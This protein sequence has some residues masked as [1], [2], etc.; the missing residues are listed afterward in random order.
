LQNPL[1]LVPSR[2]LVHRVE[3]GEAASHCPDTAWQAW[4]SLAVPYWVRLQAVLQVQDKHPSSLAGYPGAA[5]LV[6]L[7]CFV[8]DYR[9]HRESPD[10][11]CFPNHHLD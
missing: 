8:L 4:N 2:Y 10:Q 5:S 11:D 7:K 1:R 9:V 6:V 3:V